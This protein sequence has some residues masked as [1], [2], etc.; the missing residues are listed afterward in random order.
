[1]RRKRHWGTMRV[2]RACSICGKTVHVPN[3]NARRE[4]HSCP[5]KCREELHKIHVRERLHRNRVK[6]LEA[7]AQATA[8]RKKQQRKGKR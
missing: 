8:L 3:C 6:R 1:M 2:E 4:R 5:G 7:R